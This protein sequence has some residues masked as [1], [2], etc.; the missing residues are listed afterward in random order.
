MGD[1]FLDTQEQITLIRKL[2]QIT[3]VNEA[4]LKETRKIDFRLVEV[5]KEIDN[6]ITLRKSTSFILTVVGGGSGLLTFIY[7]MINNVST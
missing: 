2:E 6:W 3:A 7:W 1:N 4:I 5:E